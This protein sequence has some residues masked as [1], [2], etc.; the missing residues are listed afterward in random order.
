MSLEEVLRVRTFWKEYI[1]EWGHGDNTREKSFPVKQRRSGTGNLEPHFRDS[2]AYRIELQS[3]W[4]SAQYMWVHI[5]LDHNILS[6]V[7]SNSSR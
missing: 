4:I 6:L 2:Y 1:V 3:Q 7:V 5:S